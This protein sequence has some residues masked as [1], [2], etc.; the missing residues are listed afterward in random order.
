MGM[1]EKVDSLRPQILEELGESEPAC[2][3][4]LSEAKWVASDFC[5][6]FRVASNFALQNLTE[7][8][9]R[10]LI[11]E[12]IRHH[13]PGLAVNTIC[14]ST[15]THSE[16]GSSEAEEG[17]ALQSRPS[18]VRS[19]L[20]MFTFEQFV[21]GDSN[22]LA[23]ALAMEVAQGAGPMAVLLYGSTGC[24]KTHLLKAAARHS[25]EKFGIEVRYVTG[26]GFLNDFT[27]NVRGEYAAMHA[28]RMRYRRVDLLILDDIHFL[29]RGK[30]EDTVQELLST[31]REREERGAPM[32]LGST[33]PVE[34][35]KF[36]PELRSRLLGACRAEIRQPE[37]ELRVLIVLKI[38]ERLGMEFERSWAQAIVERSEGVR[39]LESELVRL[40]AY[41]AHLG[42]TLDD[43]LIAELFEAKPID[44]TFDRIVR[45]V[46]EHYGILEKDLLSRSKSR[47]VADPR[48]MVMFLAYEMMKGTSFFEIGQR[49]GRDHSTVMHARRKML[50]RADS[51]TEKEKTKFKHDVDAIKIAV[52]KRA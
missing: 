15:L 12:K 52:A 34:D 27:A 44:V 25:S 37:K 6:E 28:F 51:H 40:H 3:A 8:V 35:L 47:R 42:R 31:W 13:F 30:K 45:A 17:N 11:K 46:A 9:K 14:D 50:A 5:I 24:G 36:P 26:E 32:L 16:V 1:Q 48:Q 43:A 33:E 22:R 39:E 2:A 20:P 49:L 21:E 23:R 41:V 29:A 19:S 38:A 18:P 10:E 4:F 7:P